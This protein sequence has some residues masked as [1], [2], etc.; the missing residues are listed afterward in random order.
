M[1]IGNGCGSCETIN[2]MEPNLYNQINTPDYNSSTIAAMIGNGVRETAQDIN[3]KLSGI[4]HLGGQQTQAQQQKQQASVLPQIKMQ[5][6]QYNRTNT[7][8]S[9]IS[10][11]VANYIMFGIIA[12]TALAWHEAIKVYINNAIKFND[13]SPTYFISYAALATFLCVILYTYI[14]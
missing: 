8:D 7:A 2:P 10:G 4:Q 3:E 6:A 13:G 12:I 1:N 9:N 14:K 5:P 11:R